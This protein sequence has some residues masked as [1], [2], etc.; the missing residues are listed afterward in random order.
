MKFKKLLAIT[1]IAGS[2]T[3]FQTAQAE[4]F[5][6]TR[7]IDLCLG[8]H[9]AK[10]AKKA[11]LIKEIKRRGMMGYGDYSGLK[12]GVIKL[13]AT[14]CGMYMIKGKPISEKGVALRPMVYKVVHVYPHHYFV[15]Q[16][17]L[18]VKIYDRKKGTIPPALI[19]KLPKVIPPPVKYNAPGGSSH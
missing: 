1:L 2:T 3:L 19:K 11:V 16:T 13:H 12:T 7:T 17:G 9:N 4:D 18:I 5:S 10:P 14:T 15:S 8:Y 6:K